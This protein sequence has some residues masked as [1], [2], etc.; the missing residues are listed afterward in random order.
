[1]VVIREMTKQ[2]IPQVSEMMCSCYRWLGKYNGFSEHQVV[3]LVSERGSMERIRTDSQSQF[4]LVACMDGSV[5]GM[6]A[7][8]GNEVAKLFVNPNYHNQGIGTMLLNSAEQIISDAGFKEMIVGVMAR[9]AVGFYE[10]MGMSVYDET[11]LEEGA[12]SGCKTPLMR[13]ILLYD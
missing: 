6:T 8:N 13:K 1:M 5:V 2:D 12:F 9:S 3:F 4:Y 11:I 7:V 10:K